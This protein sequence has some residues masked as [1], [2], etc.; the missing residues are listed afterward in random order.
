MVVFT[1][2]CSHVLIKNHLYNK[3]SK[4]KIEKNIEF[5]TTEFVL[6]LKAK[7]IIKIGC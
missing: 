6:C 1:I 3:I 5:K 4:N 2:K 7:F